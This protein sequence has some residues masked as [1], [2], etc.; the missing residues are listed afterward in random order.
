[1]TR[2]QRRQWLAARFD[3][4]L[5][6]SHSVFEANRRRFELARD[7]DIDRVICDLRVGHNDHSAIWTVG[8]E[9]VRFVVEKYEQLFGGFLKA[10]TL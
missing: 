2:E 9:D 7:A 4:H 3:S 5:S 10:H 6:Q 8:F 1:M